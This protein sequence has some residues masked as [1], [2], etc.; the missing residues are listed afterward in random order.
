MSFAEAVIPACVLLSHMAF[1]SRFL[2]SLRNRQLPTTLEFSSLSFLIYFDIGLVA[3]VMFGYDNPFF[4][5]FF[6]APP[7]L[8]LFGALLLIAAP[9]LLD[10]GAM[11]AGKPKRLDLLMFRHLR[12]IPS[13]RIVFDV[14]AAAIC[15]TTIVLSAQYMNRG[16]IWEMRREVGQAFGPLI[17]VLYLPL[18][19]LGFYMGLSDFATRRGKA[20]VLILLLVATV[21]AVPLG[22]RTLV[23]LPLL[24]V[25]LFGQRLST[26]RIAF[27]AA[28]GLV[29]ASLALPYFKW[30]FAGNSD[31]SALVK[32]V[33][34]ND[35]N[36]APVLLT[37]IQN[38]PWVGTEVLPFVG[39]GYAYAALLYVPR[40]FLPVKPTATAQAF[41]AYIAKEDVRTAS[42]GFGISAI[43]EI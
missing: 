8:M 37:S 43:D 9:W 11:L 14:S 17:L 2:R 5:P 12:L 38:S 21:A 19:L 39:S 23:L 16:N 42:W 35:L 13:R 32:S 15:A 33:V 40:S 34:T 6:D 18:Y 1:A 41:T 24:I 10:L 4:A 29:V 25:M 36:R 3:E 28:A 7:E 30:G 31:A 20:M 26:K 27:A 22:Q